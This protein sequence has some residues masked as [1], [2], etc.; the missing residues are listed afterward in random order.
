M[1]FIALG[2]LCFGK[3]RLFARINALQGFGKNLCERL[4]LFQTIFSKLMRKVSLV[5]NLYQTCSFAFHNKKNLSI[6]V[7]TTSCFRCVNRND[8]SA[9]TCENNTDAGCNLQTFTCLHNL[10]QKSYEVSLFLLKTLKRVR[11]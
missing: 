10:K 8:H 5:A 9:R 7:S 6:L 1:P 3:Y 2:I 11:S 4:F